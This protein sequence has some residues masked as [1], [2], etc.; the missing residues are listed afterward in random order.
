MF[1]SWS[2]GE[3]EDLLLFQKST[4]VKLGTREGKI[5]WLFNEQVYWKIEELL[6]YDVKALR[7]DKER[8]KKRKIERAKTM[9]DIELSTDLVR[10]YIPDDVKTW[11][12]FRTS[13]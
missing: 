1:A 7:L 12:M 13:D 3:K 9:M 10:K 6:V 2:K 8:N 11:L 4:P 5:Y